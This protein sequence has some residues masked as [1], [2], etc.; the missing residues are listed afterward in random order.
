MSGS[1]VRIIP[2]A[3]LRTAIAGSTGKPLSRIGIRDVRRNEL[4]PTSVLAQQVAH[5]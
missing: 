5:S 1:M 4:D 2:L 3:Q